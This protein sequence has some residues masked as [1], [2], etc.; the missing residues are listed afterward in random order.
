[1]TDKKKAF[2]DV[3]DEYAR[4]FVEITERQGWWSSDYDLFVTE[5]EA[6]SIN[7]L[8]YIV[9][10]YEGKEEQY[11]WLRDEIDGWL[12]YLNDCY[13]FKIKYINIRSW[14]LGCPRMPKSSRDKLKTMRDE[15]NSLI[16]KEQEF[17]KEKQETFY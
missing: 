12:D 8:V 16:K 14:L 13:E 9:D 17:Q 6:W 7:D 10:T 3:L 11:E 2:K 4:S 5:Y 1:M 15:L